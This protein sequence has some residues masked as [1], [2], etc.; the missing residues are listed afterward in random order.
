MGAAAREGTAAAKRQGPP[1]RLERASRRR[2]SLGHRA[3]LPAL[4]EA[5]AADRVALDLAGIESGLS[6][7]RAVPEVLLVVGAAE[8]A[9]DAVAQDL[10]RVDVGEAVVVER[11]VF[12]LDPG[13]AQPAR[14]DAADRQITG[15]RV[16][17]VV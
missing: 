13:D 6:Q 7:V 10:D 12:D 15:D 1:G 9:L 16:V 14:G 8:V 2:A 5:L 17:L 3:G 4:T 11:D